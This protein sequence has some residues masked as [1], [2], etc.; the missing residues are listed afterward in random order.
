MKTAI[1]PAILA[2]TSTAANAEGCKPV[3]V[4][5]N[6]IVVGQG[7]TVTLTDSVSTGT[8]YAVTI[9][10]TETAP[11]GIDVTV[12]SPAVLIPRRE[13]RT[14]AGRKIQLQGIPSGN[15]ATAKLAFCI[16]AVLGS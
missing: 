13:C 12:V 5:F 11:A 7:K 3:Q 16:E 15:T 6:S 4:E 2:I 14:V 1:I 8:V 9:C 10:N